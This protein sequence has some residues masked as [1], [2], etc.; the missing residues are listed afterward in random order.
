VTVRYRIHTEHLAPTLVTRFFD[1][2]TLYSARGY[3][4]GKTESS[5]T[6]EIL[7]TAEDRSKIVTLCQ[8][9]R[10]QYRQEQVWFTAEPVSL[11]RVSIDAIS[12]GL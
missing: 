8:T 11:T 4:Q 7:G 10:E 9:I 6:C 5:I 1:G 2:F 3:W 12:E